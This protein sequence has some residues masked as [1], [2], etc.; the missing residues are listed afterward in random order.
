MAFSLIEAAGG[1]VPL[2]AVSKEEFAA[3]R[4][5]APARER[6][7]LAA[8]GFAA[9]PGK[10]A[11]VPG[12]EGGLGRV[13]VGYGGEPVM[14][15]LAG[16]SETLPEGDYRLAALPPGRTPAASPSAGRS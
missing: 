5:T 11:L 3:W 10:V 8:I 2:V 14:W 4:E 13:V 1:A 9:E 12:K 7:W 15:A 6:D 16:L